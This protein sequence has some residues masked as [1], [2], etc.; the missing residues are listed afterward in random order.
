LLLGV[1]VVMGL[2]W[3][4][5]DPLGVR[6]RSA[7]GY[8]SFLAIAA[9]FSLNLRAVNWRTIGFGVLLQIVLALFVLR[10]AWGFALF[11][12]VGSAIGKFL[13]FSNVGAKFVF[14]NLADKEL[15]DKLF[16]PSGGFVFAFTALPT[17]IFV[18]SF[19]T[20][21]YHVGILQWVVRLMAWA[22]KG[23]MG[24]SGAETLAASANVFM[25]QTEAPLIIKPYVDRMTDSELLALMVG[26]MATVSGGIMALFLSIG[27]NPVAILATS[28][29]AAPC[30]LFLA[31]L[32]LPETQTPETL[33]DLRSNTASPHR[34]VIDAASSGASDGMS[35]VINIAAMLIAFLALLAMLDAGVQGLTGLLGWAKPVGLKEIFGVVFAP[36]AFLIGVERGELVRMGDLLGTKLVA[37]EVL[38]FVK[39][40]KDY[41]DSS[42][43]TRQLATFA[44][45]SFANFSSIGIQLGGIG[46]MAPN[47]RPD[48]A[49]LGGLALFA[50]FLATLMNAALAGVLMP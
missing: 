42:E 50:G 3:L 9:A 8:V 28:V 49:R 33:G 14:G 5:G 41:G 10:S 11:N 40:T 43:R 38:A 29:M 18:A 4:L 25:G 27:G 16:P 46:A 6:V 20:V 32:I 36:L 35:L 17:I 19:F 39:L 34:S 45:T 37:N 12:A 22:M 30:G 23:L 31:K 2:L 48:L 26:G 7:L 15:M 21:L 24:T 44:L 1:L 47:R 13:D